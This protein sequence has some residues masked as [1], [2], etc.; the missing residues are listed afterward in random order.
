MSILDNTTSLEALLEKANALLDSES[1]GTLIDTN[2]TATVPNI[3]VLLQRL[4]EQANNIPV[5]GSGSSIK[6][7]SYADGTDE[8]IVAMVAAADR[9]EINLSDYWSVGDTRT[10]SLSA[11]SA[12]DVGE[13]HSAQTV[14]FVLMHVGGYE[15]NEATESGRTTCS[16][17]VGMKNCLNETGY[18]NSAMKNAGSWESSARRAWCNSTFYNSLP[19][20]LRG[21]FKQFKVV[22]ATEYNSSTTTTSIDYFTLPAVKEVFG[23][24][25]ATSAGYAETSYSNLAE[26]NSLFQYEWYKTTNSQI[27]TVNGS[28]Y[29]WWER[30][31]YYAD[32][33]Q[34]CRVTQTGSTN[35]AL[36]NGGSGGLSPVGCI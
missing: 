23:G 34:F 6:I 5:G 22:T 20:S 32:A 26:F 11:M 3:T 14:E 35:K 24:D 27:K 19:E 21:I 30:S 12:T 25:T 1:N 7:V 33:R 29:Y 17:I 4:L 13:S 36:A 9:G 16:F 8:E 15:L 28:A 31:P 18:M 2:L 10:V